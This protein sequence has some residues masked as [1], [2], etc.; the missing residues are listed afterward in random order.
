MFLFFLKKNIWPLHGGA[1][2]FHFGPE[3]GK[4]QNFHNSPELPLIMKI[5]AL[6]FLQLSKLKKIKCPHFFYQTSY[7][8]DISIIYIFVNILDIQLKFSKKQ[9]ANI[10][11]IWHLIQKIKTLSILQL[12]KFEK[13]KCHYFFIRCHITEICPFCCFETCN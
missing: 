6:S 11:V 3:R 5:R 10:S 4:S 12:L 2:D 1:E 8:W 9:K 13:I 7:N